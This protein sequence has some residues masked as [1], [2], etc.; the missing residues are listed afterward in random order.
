MV[1]VLLLCCD[2]SAGASVA[3]LRADLATGACESLGSAQTQE[4]T[5]HAEWLAPAVQQVLV[6]AG[7]GDEVRVPDG[8]VVGV[9][10]GPFT[11]LRVGLALAH[12]LA[13]AWQIPLYGVRS[14]DALALRA[15]DSG[16]SGELAVLTDARRREVY[17][18]TY[19]VRPAEHGDGSGAAPAGI[20]LITDPAVGPAQHAPKLPAVGAGVGLYPEFATAALAGSD[21]WSPHAAELGR[22]AAA[23]W[24]ASGGSP[25]EPGAD[26][27]GG[28]KP[29]VVA[30]RPLYLR[31]SDA[32]VP[33]QMQHA[34]A[35]GST[36][37]Q[38]T[39]AAPGRAAGTGQ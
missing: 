9:G 29:T 24:A 17:W 38:E 35:Q 16:V 12:S 19:R 3:L 28:P 2:S 39:T 15:A 30:P 22:V 36:A 25:A 31:E 13:E 32:K 6:D 33:A 26:D 4:V 8:V 27:L 11:G 1:T 21:D 18:A 23:A 34:A 14:L 10:P 20:E 37:G 7:V 5:A